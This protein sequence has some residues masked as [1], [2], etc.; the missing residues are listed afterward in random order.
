MAR[1]LHVAVADTTDDVEMAA[2]IMLDYGQVRGGEGRRWLQ[3]Y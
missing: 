1:V 3:L 2:K